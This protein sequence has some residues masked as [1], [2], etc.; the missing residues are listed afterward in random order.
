MIDGVDP[1][2][3]FLRG[4]I[5]RGAMPGAAWWVGSPRNVVAQGA[6]GLA[7]R[8]PRP[9]PLRSSTPFDLASLTKP[10]ATALLAVILDRERLL[11]LDA[12]IAS[13]LPE[14]SGSSFGQATLRDVAAHRAGLPAW[15]PLYLS[16]ATSE[17]YLATIARCERAAPPG[18]TVYSDLG[19][20]LL[21]FAV[22]R[23]SGSPLDRQFDERIARP[24]GLARCGFASASR[25]FADAAATEEDRAYERALALPAGLSHGPRTK[26]GR[27]E[28]HDGNAWGLGGVAGHA[29]LFGTAADVAAIALAILD[30]GLLGLAQDALRPM[31]HSVAEG[32]GFRTVGFVR[33]ADSETV[34]GVLPDDAVGHLGFTGTSVWIDTGRSRVYVLLTNRVHPRVPEAS[35]VPTR[36]GFHALAAALP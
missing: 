12:T 7:A 2:D 21:G 25:S 26:I 32:R 24:L 3:P 11:S 16:G 20:L 22:E 29:G 9:V 4:E 8:E 36:R 17:A 5:E 33:A 14:L 30:P 1:L 19:Y 10:L 28:V 34:G 13:V 35:F 15:M 31:L 18:A 23:A 6:S 27:G